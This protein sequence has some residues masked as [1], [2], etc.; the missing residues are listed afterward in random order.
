MATSETPALLALL[1]RNEPQ[2]SLSTEVLS[3]MRPVEQVPPQAPSVKS[4]AL[5]RIRVLAGKA[6][7][8]ARLQP[9]S[10]LRRT[11]CRLF[12]NEELFA[13]RLEEVSEDAFDLIPLDDKFLQTGIFANAV[14]FARIV[15]EMGFEGRVFYLAASPVSVTHPCGA[16]ASNIACIAHFVAEAYDDFFAQSTLNAEAPESSDDT[17]RQKPA[18]IP[19][20][21]R[22][23]L[24]E[25]ILRRFE[26]ELPYFRANARFV[27]KP[28]LQLEDASRLRSPGVRTLEFI[29]SH[30]DELSPTEAESGLWFNRRH[31]VP[32]R[33]LSETD[34]RNFS[35]YENWAIVDFLDSMAR[36]TA[37]QERLLRKAAAVLPQEA[38][39]GYVSVCE[40]L[41]E[42]AGGVRA[43]AAERMTKIGS[44]IDRLARRYH[45]ALHLPRRKVGFCRLPRRTHVFREIP[46]YRRIYEAMKRWFSLGDPAFEKA[47]CLLAFAAQSRLYEIY[48]L[49]R[50]L[51]SIQSGGYRLVARRT[52]ADHRHDDE[53]LFENDSGV[54]IC[55]SYEPIAAL[56]GSKRTSTIDLRRTSRLSVRTGTVFTLEP[57][58]QNTFYTPDIV[59]ALHSGEVRRWFIA[60]AKF[61]SVKTAVKYRTIPLAMR[62]LL[63]LAPLHPQETIEG[64]WLIC[65]KSSRLGSEPPSLQH[66]GSILGAPMSMDVHYQPLD[67]RMTANEAPSSLTRA[68][69]DAASRQERA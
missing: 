26:H 25:S 40:P 61:S 53:F 12:V 9:P 48:V 56:A 64:L 22:L 65:G 55:V 29:A 69:L 14:G 18:P 4:D 15:L 23:E 5:Y 35:I 20:E 1:G 50:M 16:A 3:E 10:E 17:G 41:L 62:Y 52:A 28:K 67:G 58:S 39:A 11:S 7:A 33:V 43:Q 60:D 49:L 44:R 59:V 2:I 34:E 42:L 27:L 30:P 21:R 24:L 37:R 68:V 32:Q 36:E 13:V 51:V 47:E 66:E 45:E 54:K 19:I 38:P 63:G 8:A 46:A 6:F 31:W 57:S